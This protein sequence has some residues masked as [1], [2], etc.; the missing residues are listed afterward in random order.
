[1]SPFLKKSTLLLS[2]CLTTM[3]LPGQSYQFNLVEIFH[4]NTGN[5]QRMPERLQINADTGSLL[6][7]VLMN[8][9]C[10]A[11]YNF[12]YQFESAISGSTVL[13]GDTI[14]RRFTFKLNPLTESCYPFQNEN[15]R[16][17]FVSFQANQELAY[18]GLAARLKAEG[19]WNLEGMDMT[20]KTPGAYLYA[21]N[22]PS[23]V[24]TAH[25]EG[26][27]KQFAPTSAD[28]KTYSFLQVRVSA[29][30]PMG[31]KA[32]NFYYEI[33]FVFEVQKLQDT[34]PCSIRPPD[35]SCCPG[36]IPVWN[37]KKGKG[38]CICPEGSSWDK[39]QQK[40]V[41]DK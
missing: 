25:W 28:D 38:E 30:S 36:T 6:F 14:Q 32:H 41:I 37:F 1:M 3:L 4:G 39:L 12:Q 9:N 2:L 13:S 21:Y 15:F 27:F 35:C 5:S 26:A 31:G 8:E 34:D 33:L 17:P 40:C 19:K 16:N 23:G 24:L 29:T 7:S 11:Y 20:F 10:P 18:S 22:Y